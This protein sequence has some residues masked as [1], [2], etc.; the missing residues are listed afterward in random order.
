MSTVTR[1][2]FVIGAAAALAAA[3]TSCSPSTRD[4]RLTIACGEPGGIYLEFGELIGAAMLREAGIDVTTRSTNGSAENLGLLAAGEVD[5]GL[6]LADSAAESDADLVALGSVYQNY[7]QCIVRADGDVTSLDALAGMR[8]SVGA[9]GSGSS[10]TT[11]RLL[12]ALAM[13]EEVEQSEQELQSALAALAAGEI[14]AM[15]WSSGIP[16]PKI[17]ELNETTPLRMLDL[18][19]ALTALEREHPG[20]YRPAVVPAGVYGSAEP[21]TTVGVPNYLLA[22]PGLADD[23]AAEIVNTLVHEAASLMPAGTVGLQ[24]LTPATLIDTGQ[25]PLHPAAL[26]R[27]RELYG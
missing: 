21:L 10:V 27:Y 13:S 12:A 11:R 16:T 1:R 18:S 8:V 4:Q 2:T 9:T 23:V 6:A 15:F 26:E 5:L 25:V 7:L 17:T 14:D 3:L 19:S 20:K 22:H 24:F